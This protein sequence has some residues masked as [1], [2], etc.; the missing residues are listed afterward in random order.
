MPKSKDPKPMRSKALA[1]YGAGGLGREIASMVHDINQHKRQWELIGFYDD[2]KQKGSIIDLLPVLGGRNEINA[3]RSPMSLVIAISDPLTKEKLVREIV[4]TNIGFPVLIH[5]A[6]LAGDKKNN[7]F[8]RGT[9]L[10]AGVILTTRIQTGDFVLINLATTVGHD[11]TIGK[12]CSI[13]PG[14]SISGS[15]SLGERCLVG[16]GARILQN[17]TV[18]EDSIIG[19][20]AVVTRSFGPASTLIGVP[21]VK[22]SQHG[23]GV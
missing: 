14:C 3:A 15:V 2:G 6:C 20:G 18:G 7:R 19:A 22:T 1:I 16:T 10:T 13:M 17:I 12:F 9:I 23:E 8:G 4:N 5:P 21:A 11:V